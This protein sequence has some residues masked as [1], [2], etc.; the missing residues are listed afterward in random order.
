M[1]DVGRGYSSSLIWGFVILI[2]TFG[3]IH[4]IIF[5]DESSHQARGGFEGEVQLLVAFCVAGFC[6]MGVVFKVG[7]TVITIQIYSIQPV[8][9]RGSL[10]DDDLCLTHLKAPD[11]MSFPFFYND[12][13]HPILYF[14]VSSNV[15]FL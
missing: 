11:T 9:D 1:G 13:A 2:Y 15:Q 3:Y 8:S 7:H 6:L 14:N 5:K 4:A 10:I 12:C